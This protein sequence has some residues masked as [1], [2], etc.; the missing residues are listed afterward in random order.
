[1][2]AYLTGDISEMFDELNGKVGPPDGLVPNLA[3]AFD[4]RS[5]STIEDEDEI[6]RYFK[7]LR[8]SLIEYVKAPAGPLVVY[9]GCACT[10]IALSH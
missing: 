4:T 1:M 5:C 10:S 8:K 6:R 3:T 2:V 9:S 7:K